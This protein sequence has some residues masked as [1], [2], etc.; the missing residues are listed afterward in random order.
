MTPPDRQFEIGRSLFREANDAF[1][2]FDVRSRRILDLNPAAMR[3]TGLEKDKARSLRLE[4][5]FAAQTGNGLD[6]MIEALTR[7]GFFNSR[8]GYSLRRP[9]QDDLSV[10]V[11][12]SRIHI[13]PDPVGLVVVRDISERKR[14]EEALKQ[15]ETR[16]KSLVASTGVIVW[17]TTAPGLIASISPAFEAITGW[18]TGE[19]I[20]RHLDL[21]LHPGDRESAARVRDRAWAGETVPRH[22]VRIVKQSGGFIEC[23]CLLVT[24]IRDNGIE[25]ILAVVRDITAQKRI[26]DVVAQGEQLRRAKEEA[27]RAAGPNPN[28]SRP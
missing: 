3:L 15:V 20:G 8:E 11:S 1:F 25:R 24:R 7:S 6:G 4:D 26:D 21:L 12:V 22:S 28:F 18:P 10:N 14:S 16:Y 2:I 5:I 9:P 13:E 23:E 27:E 17:E 19:W